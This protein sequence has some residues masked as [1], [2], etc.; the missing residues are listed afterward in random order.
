MLEKYFLGSVVESGDPRLSCEPGDLL[1]SRWSA[2][3]GNLRSGDLPRYRGQDIAEEVTADVL[4]EGL[5]RTCWCPEEWV[6]DRPVPGTWSSPTF[7][8]LATPPWASTAESKRSHAHS[9]RSPPPHP[10]GDVCRCRFKH[11]LSIHLNC[12]D[13]WPAVPLLASVHLAQTSFLRIKQRENVVQARRL[14][15]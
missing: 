5:S 11:L 6:G 2:G 15:F 8:V 12:E 3:P 9:P 4:S 10:I 7:P 14:K 1:I 13:S